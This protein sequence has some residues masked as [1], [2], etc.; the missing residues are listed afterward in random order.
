MFISS[1]QGYSGE[2]QIYCAK[3]R[4]YINRPIEKK[5]TQHAPLMP[6]Q[7]QAENRMCMTYIHRGY[8]AKLTGLLQRQKSSH[9]T[10]L[11]D[12]NPTEDLIRNGYLQPAKET[13]LGTF[14][15]S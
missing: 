4:K 14:R 8:L 10:S 3:Y 11:S 5:N 1:M 15:S 2:M 7:E 13:A 6:M 12:C 9:F